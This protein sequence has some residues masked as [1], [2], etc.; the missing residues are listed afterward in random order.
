M[1]H[2][3]KPVLGLLALLA[4]VSIGL[5]LFT[6]GVQW[7]T[8]PFRGAVAE[9]EATVANAHYR[10][11]TKASFY[12]RCASVQTKEATIRNL[13][14]ELETADEGRA[15]RIQTSLT[16]TR[17]SR[18]EAINQYNADAMNENKEALRSDNLPE[19]LDIDNF[20]TECVVV[21]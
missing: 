2:A 6:G 18:A 20:E 10:I 4:T 12:N 17:A 9:R 1:K 3:V 19:L 13:E 16:A 7:V 8:A 21:E 5:T 11:G 14:E 15:G